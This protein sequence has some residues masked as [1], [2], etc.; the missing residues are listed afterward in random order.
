MAVLMSRAWYMFGSFSIGSAAIAS[1]SAT[2]LL[3]V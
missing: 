3:Q 1:Y 2:L